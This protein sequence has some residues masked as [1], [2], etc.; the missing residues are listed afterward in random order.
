[1]KQYASSDL[2]S[3]AV[4]GHASAGKTMLTEAMLATAGAIGRMG[5][6]ATGSTVSDY[7]I[8]EKQHQISVHC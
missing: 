7:H 5:S 2:R 8:S 1:M 3:F 4:L 6:I